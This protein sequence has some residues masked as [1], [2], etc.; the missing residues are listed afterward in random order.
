MGELR[1][2]DEKGDT[3]FTWD[4]TKPEE[5]EAAQAVFATY[6][7]QGYRAARMQGNKTG[8]FIEA[9]DPKAETLLMIPRMRKG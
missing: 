3:K 8:E 5:V 6:Q 2:L 4:A 9:F 7:G 1:R